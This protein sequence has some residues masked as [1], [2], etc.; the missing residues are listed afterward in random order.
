MKIQDNYPEGKM[1][2]F[3]DFYCDGNNIFFS[4]GNFNGLYAYSMVNKKLSFL[5]KFKDEYALCIQLYG[6]V[7]NF[8]NQL[9]FTPLSANSIGIYDLY[10][11]T[12][13][14][15]ALPM[16]KAA[17]GYECKFLN[18]VIYKNSI[19][20]F[21]GYS[22][23]II[24]Y[25]IKNKKLIIHDSWYNELFNRYKKKS[26][27]LFH[28]DS[29]QINDD[30]YLPSEQYSGM[31]RYC[32]LD[33]TYEF[34]EIAGICESIHTLSYD[35]NYMWC[36]TNSK[37][38]KLNLKGKVIEEID[39]LATY[40]VKGD[41]YYSVYHREYLLL[42]ACQMSI[43]LR[44][45]CRNYMTKFE[46]MRYCKE[47]KKYTD[48]EYHAT[49]FVKKKK[50]KVFF[51]CRSDRT[52]QNITDGDVEKYL[53]AI[54]DTTGYA[55]RNVDANDIYIE[56]INF[57]EKKNRYLHKDN[58]GKNNR[59]VF[60]ERTLFPESLDFMFNVID[61]FKV[62]KQSCCFGDM[63]KKIYRLLNIKEK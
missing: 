22:S 8:E 18:S 15:I 41:F 16:P 51:M 45:D 49:D 33:N 21:P 1:L 30:I 61:S 9:I 34:I 17:C 36:S 4:A 60:Y 12:F 37:L 46:V 52:I 63:G 44:I 50:D 43:V 24:E 56:S 57:N 58:K 38:L 5:G 2:W 47:E 55:E 6:N 28:F 11:K 3:N 7:N 62:G 10:N 20:A 14:S 25:S 32:L 59:N 35:G 54:I 40:G 48:Y 29:V 23:Y 26:N 13:E 31:F 27:L 39:I 42:F 19:F 53:E